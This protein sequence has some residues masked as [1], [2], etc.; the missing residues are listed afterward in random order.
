MGNLGQ[1]QAKLT[2]P[3][4]EAYVH[5]IAEVYGEI[6]ERAW[7]DSNGRPADSKSDALS[8]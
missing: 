5:D 1:T 2:G 7:P 4:S 8:S 6:K 3:W